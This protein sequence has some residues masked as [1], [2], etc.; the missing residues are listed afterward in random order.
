[1]PVS[2]HCAACGNDLSRVRAQIDDELR[3]PIVRC[4]R[5]GYCVV[6]R[7]LRGRRTVRR[8]RRAAR[9][10]V[11]LLLQ[12]LLGGVAIFGA[13]AA[14][15]VLLANMLALAVGD[16]LAGV[17]LDLFDLWPPLRTVAAFALPLAVLAGIGLWHGLSF[18][19]HRFGRAVAVFFLAVA[20]CAAAVPIFESIDGQ[21][22]P[23]TDVLW[24]PFVACGGVL[25]ASPVAVP[26]VAF[27]RRARRP[28]E[29]RRRARYALAIANR[30][31]RR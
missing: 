2:H 4:G 1:M 22:V 17:D 12:V 7:P 16:E 20:A 23:S 10:I 8:V 14:G 13:I 24:M 27:G 29:E 15:G 21:R 26:M 9:G 18:A 3:L 19:H 31:S 28:A 6:K 30:S 25:A 5:C 11:V